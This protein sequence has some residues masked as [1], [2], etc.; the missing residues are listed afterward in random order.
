M[1]TAVDDDA[2]ATIAY[3]TPSVFPTF[4]GD[5][6]IDAESEPMVFDAVTSSKL[7]DEG[8]CSRQGKLAPVGTLVN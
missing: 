5:G 2:S 7:R 4:A 3:A 8:K 6:S 1:T